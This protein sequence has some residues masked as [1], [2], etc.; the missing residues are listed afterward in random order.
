MGQT[1]NLELFR[2]TAEFRRKYGYRA[3]LNDLTEGSIE[4]L[5]SFEKKLTRG[6]KYILRSDEIRKEKKNLGIKKDARDKWR[7]AACTSTLAA[8]TMPYFPKKLGKLLRSNKGGFYDYVHDE[9][10]DFMEEHWDMKGGTGTSRRDRVISINKGDVRG[11]DKSEGYLIFPWDKVPHYFNE[12]LIRDVG[13]EDFLGG[14][15]E[16]TAL[17]R[18]CKNRRHVIE[19]YP[20][21]KTFQFYKKYA[22]SGKIKRFTPDEIV[23]REWEFHL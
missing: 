22:L 8:S 4:I 16:L 5:K 12:D 19:Y 15:I 6:Y 20:G 3:S 23:F 21:Y 9:L 1:V 10:A 13:S 18:M 17:E 2:E 14:Q 11:G 7:C